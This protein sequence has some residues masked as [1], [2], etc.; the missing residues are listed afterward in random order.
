[1]ETP[2]PAEP[3]AEPAASQTTGRVVKL[4]PASTGWVCV[5]C[6]RHRPAFLMWSL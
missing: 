1:M 2:P 6:I 5:F 3:V 4:P